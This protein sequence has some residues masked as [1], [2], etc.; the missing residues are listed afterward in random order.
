[1]EPRI[2]RRGGASGLSGP[3]RGLLVRRGGPAVPRL[4]RLR[5]SSVGRSPRGQVR[6]RGVGGPRG[7]DRPCGRADPR[8]HRAHRGRPA[9]GDR[10]AQQDHVAYDD[11]LEGRPLRPRGRGPGPGGFLVPSNARDGRRD[12]GGPERSEER[13]VGKE[14]RTW[15]LAY[16]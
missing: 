12:G 10:L 3:S 2:P 11:R 1:E 4:D 9:G 7:N 13:R 8:G 14:W 6:R 16:R 15:W 5:R